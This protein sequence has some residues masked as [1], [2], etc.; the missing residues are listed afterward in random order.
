MITGQQ[1]SSH[2]L[3]ELTLYFVLETVLL[4]TATEQCKLACNYICIKYLHNCIVW[5]LQPYTIH[6]TGNSLKKQKLCTEV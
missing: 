1:I 3:S 2:S 6:P 5:S 4:I